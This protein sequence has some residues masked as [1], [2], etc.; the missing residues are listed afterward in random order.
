MKSTEGPDESTLAAELEARMGERGIR[1]ARIQSNCVSKAYKA[2]RADGT[3]FFTKW[4]RVD[5]AKTLGFLAAV[6]TDPILPQPI[7]SG[8][9]AFCGG[10][11][12]S[13]VW[14]ESAPVPVE[15]MTDAQFDSFCRAYRRL[16]HVLQQAP[17]PLGEPTDG[18]ALMSDV[19]AFADRF[20]LL[21]GLLS[22]LLSLR[23]TDYTYPADTP[24]V[25]IHG[26]F[27]VGNFGFVGDEFQVFYDFDLLTRGSEV[28][29]LAFLLTERT[30]RSGMSRRDVSR[31]RNRRNQLIEL[32]GRPVGE[33]RVAFNL[34]RLRMAVKLIERHPRRV[35]TMWNVLVRD[36]RLR[37]LLE[38][39]PE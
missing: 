12:S 27:H 22:S 10:W 23:R 7:R 9:F 28:D 4:A 15:R 13:Y 5:S 17:G 35:R 38:D 3:F 8:T 30:R 11:V 33:W 25:V 26:D 31:L 16:A 21:K 6:R 39:L 36:R 24:K 19:R 32:V 29:D 34:C 2:T 1:L 20:P 18:D 37:V 14:R